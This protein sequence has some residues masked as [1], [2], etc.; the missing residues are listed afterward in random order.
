M[1]FLRYP[2]LARNVKRHRK[3]PIHGPF[4]SMEMFQKVTWLTSPLN[5]LIPC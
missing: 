5:P 2:H 3:A 1:I 4:A